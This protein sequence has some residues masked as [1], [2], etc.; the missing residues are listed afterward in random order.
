MQNPPPATDLT[1]KYYDPMLGENSKNVTFAE[2]VS[3]GKL[4][5]VTSILLKMRFFGDPSNFPFDRF[6]SEVVC[7]FSNI[8]ST[9]TQLSTPQKLV[10]TPEVESGWWIF[11]APEGSTYKLIAFRN[12]LTTFIRF[13]LPII[14]LLLLPV[15]VSI[16]HDK[17][18]ERLA[19]I[20]AITIGLVGGSAESPLRC[21]TV[22]DQSKSTFLLDSFLLILYCILASR[23]RSE[24]TLLKRILLF[25]FLPYPLFVSSFLFQLFL[26]QTYYSQQAAQ[27]W[28]SGLNVSLVAAHLAFLSIPLTR[29]FQIPKQ[30][31]N[32]ANKTL[33]FWLGPFFS[34]ITFLPYAFILYTLEVASPKV[35]VISIVAVFVLFSF[36][37]ESWI[38][39]RWFGL[40]F[41][42]AGNLM[43]VC[44]LIQSRLAGF[45]GP[46]YSPDVSI[47]R[48]NIPPGIY[49]IWVGSSDPLSVTLTI[50][51]V[52]LVI[53]P[54]LVPFLML[55]CFNDKTDK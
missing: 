26:V 49:I 8:G 33:A 6:S 11:P 48:E 42:G 47:V 39:K 45:T 4:T 53:A 25:C 34:A 13:G 55:S 44:L 5:Y 43:Y 23:S 24:S 16:P 51:S 17:L 28:L 21:V 30:I 1:V 32:L 54:T 14:G 35:L 40:S 12:P 20:I 29:I 18:T 36:L 22:Y 10:I 38:R 41:I 31:F 15:T 3:F 2:K 19:A 27:V 37:I 7:R 46:S 52:Y 9:K 50:L